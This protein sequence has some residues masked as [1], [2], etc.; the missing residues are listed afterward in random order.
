MRMTPDVAF[1][2]D[3]NSGVPVY[4][5]QN[6]GTTSPWGQIGGTSLSSPCFAAIGA[7]IAQG[8]AIN[9]FTQYNS[10]S[11]LTK[12]YSL[13]SSDF[14]DIT[15][16]NN[17]QPCLTGYDLVTGRG[18][19]IA[20]AFVADMVGVPL[21]PAAPTNLNL[22]PNS[23]TGISNQDRI[24]KIKTPLITGNA[25]AGTTII[26][27]DGSTQVGTTTTDGNGNWS[28]ISAALTDGVHSMSATASDA[29]GVSL[30]SA[31]LSITIDTVA[32]VMGAPDLASASDSGT[33]NTD[34]ITNVTTPTFTGTAETG[35]TVTILSDGTFVGSTIASSG[36]YSLATSALADGTH[37]ITVKATDIA[38]N[39]GVP[40]P[41]LAVTIDTTA[42]TVLSATFDYDA[43]QNLTYSFSEN[44]SG[45]ALGGLSLLNTTTNQ[46]VNLALQFTDPSQAAVVT[47]PL[48]MLPDGN[49]TATLNAGAMTDAAGNLSALRSDNFFFLDA[50][51]NHDGTVNSLDFNA[52]ATNF[53]ASGVPFS[54]GD[55]N[56]DGTV[57]TLDFNALATRFGTTLPAAATPLTVQSA[58]AI[59]SPTLAVMLKPRPFSGDLIGDGDAS[60]IDVIGPDSSGLL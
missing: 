21:G 60:L 13:N 23:D 37:Q 36:S 45:L 57:D 24:T 12:V 4:D 14:H 50:D 11:F 33:S 54:G 18:S 31:P 20:N 22:P 48:G 56:Y 41:A 34:N 38:G 49:Y 58:L 15:S 25:T 3:P 47:F 5:A 9:G 40:G 1:D 53:G 8:R 52:V 29:N 55:F 26:L 35:S 51:A 6:N 39:V 32:P 42:P 19:P 27:Y 10:Q 46:N 2:A 16:G 59:S 30:F 43:A 7:I 17:G 28:I 44:V